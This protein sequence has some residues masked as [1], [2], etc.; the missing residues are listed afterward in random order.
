MNWKRAF[1]GVLVI[2]AL[3]AGGLFMYR[4]YFA[5]RPAESA[6][7]VPTLS[8]AD[9]RGAGGVAAEGQLLPLR[10]AALA[11]AAGGP[12][13]E[14]VAPAGTA[15]EA[16]DP[17]LRLESADQEL[18]VRRAEA[19]LAA[20]EAN[21]TAAQAGLSAA[22]VAIAAAELGVAAA[23]AEVALA[24][25]APRPEEIALGES[26]V[27]LAAARVAQ[28]EAAQALV[29]EGAG[30]A[31]LRAAEADLRAA[32]AAAIAPRLQLEEARAGDDPDAQTQAERE[33]AA[34]LA[35]IDA[36]QLA[37]DEVSGGATEAQRRAAAAG[38]A[39]ATAQRGAAQ[40]ELDLL[41]AGGSPEAVAVAEAGL[42]GARAALADAQARAESAA[43]AAARAQADVAAAQAAL[44]AAQAALDDRALTAPF[45]G[46]VADVAVEPGEVVAAGV[47]AVALADFSGWLVET[48]DLTELDV[49]GVAAGDPA[50]ARIDALPDLTLPGVVTAVSPVARDL[51]GDV[52]Y[53]VTVRLDDAGD[54]PLRWGMTAFVAFDEDA[55][56]SAATAAEGPATAEGQIVPR[57]AADLAFQ[58]GGTVAE[59]LVSAGQAVSAGD[60]LIRLDATAVEAG[61]RGAEAALATAEANL[62]AARAGA[63]QAEAARQT[64]AAAVA[65]AEAQ[66]AQ[67]QAG[68]RPEELAAA[69]RNVSAAESSLAGAVARR[70]AALEV[71]DAAVR[72]AEAQVAAAAARLTGLQENY[73]TL[74]TTC[75]TLPDGSEVCPLL[76]AP[77]ESL[78]A[79]VA[80]AEAALSAAQRAL[81]EARA[82]PTPAGQRAAEADVAVAAAQRDAAAAQLALLEAGARPEQVQLAEIGLERAQLG[83][84]RAGVAAQ[85]AAAA[86]AQ[87]EAGVRMAEADVAEAQH[88][89]DRLTLT[90]PFAGTVG[91][92]LVEAG[93]LVGPGVPVAQLAGAGW[94]VET[95]DLVELD[96]VR[97]AEGQPVE[98]TVDA[99]PGETL[100]GTVLD[101]ARVAQLTR[102]DV[103]YRVRVA[104]D[105]YP[106][107]PLR[108]GMTALATIG[109]P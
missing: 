5:P 27:A 44:D 102:G 48:T 53:A 108:W 67:T 64:A 59:T 42:T 66:L 74:I 45:A 12:V 62:A 25:A 90:A 87:A 28:A 61:L 103:T 33:Y 24:G 7:P 13:V 84:E 17:L 105:D 106:D 29:L 40:A 19:G 89:L 73:D 50:E 47:P 20:A 37:V 68:A 39:A 1:V 69:Q 109:G 10:S 63:T 76:G 94:L 72:A 60:P 81:D 32:E 41:L 6:A 22:E 3:L 23:E 15:V 80:A 79:Q 93:E 57:R 91:E 51:R 71:S 26:G 11:F 85:E 4:Q 46:V 56:A 78:R 82:G 43:A 35:A 97:V 9:V 8:P 34:A 36:A 65:A 98:V 52:T 31:R 30:E 21:L 38:L 58:T 100:R 18:A 16:G 101:V 77:E 99:L 54:A 95:T 86:V 83:L 2:V 75:V 55:P 70:D 14:V 92:V 104:L 107:L 96:V 49:A 88:T